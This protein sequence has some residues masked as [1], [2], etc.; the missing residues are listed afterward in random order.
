MPLMAKQK[1][2][3][4]RRDKRCKVGMLL[5]IF[6]SFLF[7][8]QNRLCFSEDKPA[9]A[10]LK[11]VGVEAYGSAVFPRQANFNT[12]NGGGGVS[13]K[14]FFS[15]HFALGTAVELSRQHFSA[16]SSTSAGTIE[17]TLNVI[18]WT[19][20]AYWWL[21]PAHEKFSVYMGGGFSAIFITNNATGTISPGGRAT[22]DFAPAFGG[23][24][25]TGVQ[26]FLNKHF[27]LDGNVRFT[28]AESRSEE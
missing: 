23:H 14:Y 17:G 21:L 28:W 9:D 26:R 16:T 7:V 8:S 22:I 12:V 25:V 20:T 13:A 19:L 15:E 27:A 18:P 5:T 4:M 1:E 24:I 6:L 3:R 11:R 2:G 10:E